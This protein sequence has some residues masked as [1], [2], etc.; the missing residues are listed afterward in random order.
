M[1]TVF[2]FFGQDLKS[3]YWERKDVVFFDE[4]G[5]WLIDG[6]SR[7][8]VTP[9]NLI[10]DSS[11]LLLVDTIE[12][13][14]RLRAWGPIWSRWCGRGDQYELVLRE[15]LLLIVQIAS[16][17]RKLNIAA[18][19]M[20]T[21][22]SHHVD[23]LIFE[24]ASELSG[25][26]VVFLYTNIFSNR[27]LPLI[28]IGSIA[29]REPLGKQI[30]RFAY[31]DLLNEFVA[32][33]QQDKPP[34]NNY[35]INRQDVSWFFA[36]FLL[37]RLQ[38]K[39]PVRWL[40]SSLKNPL[41]RRERQKQNIFSFASNAY[42]FQYAAQ[43]LQQRA[44][45]AYLRNIEVDASMHNNL[46]KE[47]TP[48][49]LVAANFQPEATS[50]PEG[51]EMNNHIDIVL[52]LRNRGYQDTVLYKEHPGTSLYLAGGQLL[53]VGM[54]RSRRYYEQLEQLGCAF[55]ASGFKLSIDPDKNNWYLPVTI[56]GTIAIERS[57][58]GFHT[59]VTGHPWFKGLPGVLQ[60]S[61]IESLSE[62][63][64]E[65]IRQDPG[66]ARR[67]FEF[68][69]QMLS[70]KTITNVPGI[71]TGIPLTGA[72]DKAA[73]ASEFDELLKAVRGRELIPSR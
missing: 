49:L 69:D 6:N 19:I 22:I 20:H 72:E 1:K 7:E 21:G 41:W 48:R 39:R 17:L 34:K 5:W 30:S 58:A 35:K 28:Q 16:G 15:A 67:A 18:C 43:V 36:L 62:I 59:I 10:T 14:R 44:A 29:A 68:L 40:L 61:E 25:I 70:G 26:K 24:M 73:F 46:R 54:Y 4:Q 37:L 8:P 65:W 33:K 23:S 45:I 31:K 50:F 71:G 53:R 32:I 27:L 12:T 63:R 57:L 38:L 55:V 52:E 11:E 3:L 13:V 56:T 42:L 60:L 9:E 47:A 2:F 66:L 51:W 64:P